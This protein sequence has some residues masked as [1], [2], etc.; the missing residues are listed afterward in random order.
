MPNP[1]KYI[2]DNDIESKIHGNSFIAEQLLVPNANKNNSNRSVMWCS[3]FQQAPVPCNQDENGEFDGEFPLVYSRFENQVGKYSSGYKATEGDIKIIRKFERNPYNYILVVYN[4]KTKM[5]DII[6]RTECVHITEK[7][8]YRNNNEFIDSLEIND[9]V[10][11]GEVLF[12]NTSYDEYMNL[13][14]GKNLKAV[15]YSHKDWTHEDAVVISE[16]AAKKLSFY[17]VLTP[18]I[19]VN[20]ND[21]LLNI[22]GNNKCFPDIGEMVNENQILLCRRRNQYDTMLTNLKD[23]NHYK[24]GDT[25]YYA[26]GRVVDIRVYSNADVEKLRTLPY[27]RQI[28]KYIDMEMTYCK[29]VVESL[30]DIVEKHTEECTP[31]LVSEYNDC[32]MKLDPGNYY[33]FDNNRFDNVVIEFTILKENHVVRGS[34]LTGRYGCFKYFLYKL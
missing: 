21:I 5:Y 25:P 20:T 12:K 19:N 31:E 1:V 30:E 26:S 18:H 13:C 4:Y 17:N 14:Y 29:R 3:H 22:Y 8:G 16:S 23:L 9:K 32:K 2:K 24:Q 28:V 11:D 33:E 6:Y 27:Y 34:K 7:Y 15:Y 10:K